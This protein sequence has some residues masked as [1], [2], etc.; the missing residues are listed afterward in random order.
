[1]SNHTRGAT[2]GAFL[3]G[4]ATFA[5]TAFGVLYFV[6][7]TF[8]TRADRAYR[9]LSEWTPE[10]IA[11]DPIGYLDFVERRG[12]EV[13]GELKASEIAIAQ[14]R[15]KLEEMQ[16][17]IGTRDTAGDA[18]LVE[19]KET[20]R[21]AEETGS[22]PV[23]WSGAPRDRDW[24]RRQIVALHHELTTERQ[25]AGKVEGALAQLAVQRR[26][27]EEARARCQ[28]QLAQVGAHRE[29]LRVDALSA[30]LTERLIEMKSV[31]AATSITA[32]F[33][34][35]DALLSLED[36]TA[37]EATTIDDREFESILGS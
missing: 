3:F 1:M 15:A 9:Q 12:H 24:M 16:G 31:L 7:D 8:R 29:M 11:A 2:L 35:A 17:T 13:L 22:W 19:L 21:R 30:E 36:L 4:T 33:V 32:D 20:Y 28:E 6:S 37:A 5:A 26:R 25:L 34:D 14:K 18:A 23:T 27:V 10:N